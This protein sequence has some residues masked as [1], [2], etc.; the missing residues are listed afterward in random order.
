VGWLL[1]TES[2][3]RSAMGWCTV[4]N[5]V[6]Y[7]LLRGREAH[8]RAVWRTLCDGRS[9]RWCLGDKVGEPLGGGEVG[10]QVE[11]IGDKA[12]AQVVGLA[13]AAATTAPASRRRSPRRGCPGGC[14]GGAW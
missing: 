2:G 3:C 7:L 1:A 6:L 11:R 5:T 9:E 8:W 4:Q 14:S 13:G 12:A 10:G